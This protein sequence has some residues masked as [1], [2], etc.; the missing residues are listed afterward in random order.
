MAITGAEILAGNLVATASQ[1]RTVKLWE[2][3]TGALLRTLEHVQQVNVV[4]VSPNQR[5]LA[6]WIAEGTVAI[7]DVETGVQ[8]GTIRVDGALPAALQFL[9]DDIL[10]A[11]GTDGRVRVIQTEHPMAIVTVLG[12]HPNLLSAL[13]TTSS[14]RRVASLDASGNLLLWV[15]NRDKRPPEEV[16]RFVHCQLPLALEK[17]VLLPVEQ[18]PTDC[19]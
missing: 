13:A 1:D 2:P 11:G 17:G 12:P 15:L 5:Q 10:L 19:K 9:S 8:M 7:W 16:R 3:R 18:T 4:A 6:A 14:N